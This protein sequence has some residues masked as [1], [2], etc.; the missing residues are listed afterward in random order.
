[1][2]DYHAQEKDLIKENI[3]YDA[4]ILEHEDDQDVIDEIVDIVV[5]A[6]TTSAPEIKIGQE[7]KPQQSVRSRFEKLNYFTVEYI[8]YSLSQNQKPVKNIKAYLLTTIYNA[9]LTAKNYYA[10]AGRALWNEASPQYINT[11]P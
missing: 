8:L 1:M 3:D 11:N 5:D 4:L 6:C 10:A 7:F 2:D 9:T